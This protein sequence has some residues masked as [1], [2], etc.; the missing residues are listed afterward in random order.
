M[1]PSDELS[2]YYAELLE[3]SYDCVDRVVPN[4]YFPMGQTGG[5]LRTWWRQLHGSDANLNDEQL[6]DM[7][8]TLSRRLRAYCTKHRVPLIDAEAGQRKHET[9]QERIPDSSQAHRPP[10]RSSV[11]ACVQVDDADTALCQGEGGR[12]QIT[13]GR[14]PVIIR[15][16]RARRLGSEAPFECSSRSRPYRSGSVGGLW[17]SN[18]GFSCLSISAGYL[19]VSDR[20]PG[21]H[22][23]RKQAQICVG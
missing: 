17:G 19:P 2:S 7:A 13:R 8:G 18:R 1:N 15:S 16:P 22:R 5:G 3:G 23:P 6:R 12:M 14:S 21:Y 9:R 20:W 10:S 4:A 11:P